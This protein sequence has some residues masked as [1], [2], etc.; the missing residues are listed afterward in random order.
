[1]SKFKPFSKSLDYDTRRKRRSSRMK[2]WITIGL[3]AAVTMASSVYAAENGQFNFQGT[4][5]RVDLVDVRFSLAQFSDTPRMGEYSYILAG[6]NFKVVQ[7]SC[8]LLGPGDTRQVQ[9]RIN[10]VGNQ[11]VRLLNITT[12]AAPGLA[13]QWPDDIPE[14]PNLTNAV[15]VPGAVSDVYLVNITWDPAQPN[16]TTGIFRDFMLTLDYQNAALPI[17]GGP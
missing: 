7:I 17:P 9:I 15:L 8:L 3:F 14:S 16:I 1:M 2:L 6:D 10:N 12:S 13:I 11:A 5:A 4:A